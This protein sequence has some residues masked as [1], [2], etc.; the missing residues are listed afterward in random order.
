MNRLSVTVVD[1]LGMLVPGVVLLV[2]FFLLPTG[3]APLPEIVGLRVSD[4]EILDDSWVVG[5]LCLATAYVLGFLLRQLAIP[6]MQAITKERWTHH[7]RREAE[8]LG[9]SLEAALGDESLVKSLRELAE[10]NKRDPGHHAP[11]FHLVKRLIRQHPELWVEVERLEAEIRLL[12]GLFLPFLL[13][14]L[15]GLLCFIAGQAGW[16]TLMA[17][18]AGGAGVILYVFPGR[19]V[20]EVRHAYFL[21]L[22]ALKFPATKNGADRD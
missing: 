6:V 17:L 7:L 22:V 2:A 12:A 19:R 10:I 11:F 8:I 5:V 3:L 14:L 20:K 4:L 9:P 15:D 1:L 16:W 21:A 18:G 13:L